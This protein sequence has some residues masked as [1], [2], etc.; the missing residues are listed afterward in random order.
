MKCL[1]CNTILKNRL[2][3][4]IHLGV[5]GL[6][7]TEYLQKYEN[8]QIPK[9]SC[10]NFSKYKSGLKFRKTCGKKE[11]RKKLQHRWT[12][13]EKENI[14][15]KR[16]EYLLK[17][18]GKTAWEKRSR[19]ELSILE[20]WF[21]DN[22]ILKFKLEEKYDIINE[23]AEFPYFIDFA[24]VNI[25]LAVEL[26]GPAHFRYGNVRFEHDLK[27]DKFLLEKGWKI[28]R[29]A[30][31]EKEKKIQEFLNLLDNLNEYEY[32]QKKLENHIYRLK[33]RML[34]KHRTKAEYNLFRKER[35]LKLQEERIFKIKTSD[36][37]LKKF[38]WVNKVSKL[39]GIRYSKIH[40]WMIRYAP[41]I[42]ETCFK[43]K[44]G[45]SS[46]GSSACL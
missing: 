21:Y 3:L 37:D 18:T 11:C 23:Y 10:G 24:F 29:I 40:K 5:H 17:R 2:G 33:P 28:F 1:V 15:K 26:D 36:I 7:L 30:Y 35:S 32:K 8:F 16:F 19:G 41:E 13:K 38:G 45:R 31:N 34:K 22:V 42:L 14:R 39:I 44:L 27:K 6:S 12:E 20:Q 43:K 25:K 46:I 9:C 4:S